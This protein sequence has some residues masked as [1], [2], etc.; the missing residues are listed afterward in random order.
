MKLYKQYSLRIL[1][2]TQGLSLGVVVPLGTIFA[3]FLI[4]PTKEQFITILISILAASVAAQV[5]HF[6][7]IAKYLKEVKNYLVQRENG[8]TISSETYLKVWDTAARIPIIFAIGG[9]VQWI[10]AAIII[11]VPFLLM[12]VTT[13][14]QAFYFENIMIFL[15]LINILLAFVGAEAASH[16]LLKKDAFERGFAE[17]ENPFYRRLGK[18]IP[19]MFCLS[20]I[21]LSDV[22]MMVSFKINANSLEK[23]YSNQLYNFNSSNEAA[24]SVLFESLE[25]S[26]TEFAGSKEV[27][28]AFATKQYGKLTPTLRRI[29]ENPA[30]FIENTFVTSLDAGY[31]VVATGSPKG[32]GL[33]FKL[34]TNPLIKENIDKA[35]N[36]EIHF[37]IAEASPITK[38]IVIFVSA[39]VKDD[40]GKT[41]GIVGFPFLIGDALSTFLKNVHIGTTGYS[42]LLDRA[43]KMVWHPNPKYLLFDLTSDPNFQELAKN[44]GETDAFTNPWE[45]SVFL[46]RKKLNPKYGFQFYSTIDL[47]EIE[48]E[49]YDALD[50]LM[51][52]SISG[53]LA[54]ALFMYVLFYFRFKPLRSI[55]KTLERMAEGD[56]RDNA[57]LQSSDEFGKLSQGLNRTIAQVSEVVQVN[58]SISDDMAASAEE[59]T[60][61]L[62]SLSSNAQTQAA[63][64]EEISA[65]IE[66]ISAAVQN[67][68]AQAED[69]FKKVEFLR[70]QMSELSEIIESMG[71]EVGEASAEVNHITNEAK[72]G[73]SSLDSMRNSI[74]KIS[75]S[76]QEI[77]SVI[78]IINNISEQINLLALNAAIEAA[79][80][81][82]YGRGFAVVADEI[83][84][85]AEKTA[86]SI[87]DIDELI[88]ANE[89]EITNGTVT[90]EATISLIQ[91]IIKGVNSFNAMTESIERNTKNQL[92]INVKVSDEVEK[93]NQISRGIKLS[94]E[95]Q[96]NAIGEVAQAIFS[97]N[98]L[99]QSTAAGLEQMTA[100]S[101]GIS[102]L[103]DTLKK[104]IN[105]FHLHKS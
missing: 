44:A 54:I 85:L 39:P 19:I 74:T 46:L 24:M 14:T 79:R 23:A 58:Q 93:V 51:Y 11:L 71:K 98:D 31:P 37:G 86:T 52:L 68:D 83:G 105:F 91:R 3:Y 2:A 32:E 72:T 5:V 55:E 77:G 29:L 80:A 100:T 78:E 20:I 34:I 12:D 27:K 61:A 36:G 59:M 35:L 41:I 33:G 47:D 18:S 70:K 63:A 96:K 69:Q 8:E 43:D 94:M 84:K 89:K 67:V 64:A 38:K 45:G 53:A 66:E 50:G 9:A 97:I 60:V 104:K 15:A 99:T 49:C 88:Q 76:S 13:K 81:G 6:G 90:I 56:L 26:I 40:K 95:E 25:I 42:F 28:D 73:Q 92:T 1:L 10:I 17:K 22:Y 30:S 82:I 102:N 101:N 75:E 7:F 103:A 21:M 65:S 4:K 62:N 16:F 87:K 48:M 57:H